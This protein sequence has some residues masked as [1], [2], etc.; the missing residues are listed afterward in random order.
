MLL[1]RNKLPIKIDNWKNIE[2]NNLAIALNVLYAKKEKI[3]PDFVPK[4][5]STHE[6]QVIL[7]KI[8]NNKR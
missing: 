6:K 3:Y 5:N 2:K 4:Y 1:R 8:P 7:L